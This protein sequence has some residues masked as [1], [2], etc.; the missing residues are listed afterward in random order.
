[1]KIINSAKKIHLVLYVFI[2]TVL[3]A[4]NAGDGSSSFTLAPISAPPVDAP[5]KITK[6]YPEPV[7]QR[8]EK[9]SWDSIDLLNPSVIKFKGKLYNYFSGYDGKIWRTGVATSVDG[10]S[11]EKFSGNPILE[12]ALSDWD[13]SYIAANGSAVVHEGKVFYFYQG[14]DKAGRTQIGLATSE[15]GL[16]FKKHSSP[17]FGIGSSS[18]WDSKAVADP[19]VI[20]K[21]GHLYLYYLGQDD[22]N[23]QRLG[24][25][26][27]KDGVNWVRLPSNPILDVGPLG[28]FDENGL[29]EPSIAYQAPFFYMLYTGRDSKEKR[30][31]GYATSTDGTHWKKMSF[32]GLIPEG[33]RKPWFSK[34]ICD[35][36]L[37]QG[38]KGKWMVWFGGGDKASPDQNLNG[39]VGLMILDLGQN[40]DGSEFDPNFNWSASPIK[41]TNIFRGSYEIE[42]E[43]GK[44]QVWVGPKS[45]ISLSTTNLLPGKNLIVQ[46]WAPA[47]MISK[48]PNK[49]GPQTISLAINGESLIKQSFIKDESFTLTIPWSK[50]ERFVVSAD[51]IDLEITSDRSLTP[52]SNSASTDSRNLA[53]VL[54]YIG[55]K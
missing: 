17:V 35:T 11:W 33:Q 32:N 3:I 7:L 31:I 39:Q 48:S 42:G 19:Y 36:T 2:A 12:P 5:L 21:N 14:V 22:L 37:L 25:A 40:R 20:S 46:G 16:H 50:L 44:R 54:K 49:D 8:G 47:A 43:A 53:F 10:I 6:I 41:S 1:M 55:F 27:S 24:I 9:A 28:A 29:G 13:T 52:S 18:T 38:E 15:D 30:N 23:V 45:T 34:V 51:S 4:C 26:K